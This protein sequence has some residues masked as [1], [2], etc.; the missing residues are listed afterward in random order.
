[1]R[2]YYP[3]E[4]DLYKPYPLPIMEAQQNNIGRGAVVTLKANGAIIEP[5]GEGLTFWAKKPDGTVSY[6]SATQDGT[7]IKLDFTNQMLS[8]PGIV[9]VEIRMINGTG[10][11]KTD[12][13]TPI[14]AVKVNESNIDDDA[15]ESTNEYSALVD[16][17]ASVEELKKTG[18]KGDAATIKVGTVKATAS[19]GTPTIVNS[20]TTGDAVFDFT[21]PRGD[22]GDKGDAATIKVGTVKATASGGTPTIVNSGTTGDAVFDFTLPRG[23]KGDKGDTGGLMSIIQ[24]GRWMRARA[25]KEE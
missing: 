3:I 17:I 13:S 24:D 4:V 2:L 8:V 15:A 5:D 22:K 20:G 12:I 7:S 1:M 19:G 21:L 23:D 11:N 25:V 10:T 6:L 9:Q 18:L 16:A 14:F